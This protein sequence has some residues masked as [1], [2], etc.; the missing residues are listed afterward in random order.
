L[1]CKSL[2]T[3]LGLIAGVFCRPILNGRSRTNTLRR[4]PHNPCSRQCE[5]IFIRIAPCNGHDLLHAF[6]SF[7]AIHPGEHLAEE[8]KELGI[9]AAELARQ[10]DVPTNRV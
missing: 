10:L 6:L 2:L 1:C 9:S 4:N 3:I 8:P 5:I 7:S